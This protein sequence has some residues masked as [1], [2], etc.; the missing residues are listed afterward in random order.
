[1]QQNLNLKDLLKKELLLNKVI[2]TQS[3]T[4]P[5]LITLL[6]NEKGIEKIYKI[7]ERKKISKF[8]IFVS[9][10]NMAK[11]FAKF[12][13]EDEELF[14]KYLPGKYTLIMNMKDN[15]QISDAVF[16]IDENGNKKI[17]IRIPALEI[18]QQIIKEIKQPIVATSANISGK[19]TPDSLLNVE[20]IILNQVDSIVDL[21]IETTKVGS[22]I[23]D[24]SGGILK[25]I[26]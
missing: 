7:K 26:R 3:D 24:I 25:I 2:L 17:G 16:S 8:S 9:D 11:S 23:I 15:L 22:T 18:F 13:Q 6:S 1:M 14:K 12:S 21:N 20:N 4:V 19:E 5:A 10:I